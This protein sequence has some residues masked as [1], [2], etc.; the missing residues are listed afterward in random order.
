[1]KGRLRAKG[2]AELDAAGAGWGSIGL[3]AFA[4]VVWIAA[5]KAPVGSLAL[6]TV[7]WVLVSV[8]LRRLRHQ[9]R[10]S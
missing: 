2:V 9:L 1:L 6:A 8:S 3:A 4:L 5:K 10:K 7:V